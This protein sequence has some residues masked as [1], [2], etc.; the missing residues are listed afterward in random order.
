[1]LCVDGAVAVGDVPLTPGHAAFVAA[2]TPATVT[3][4]GQV[5]VA[6]TG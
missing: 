5:F 2:G 1:M 3:G 6:T 4:A